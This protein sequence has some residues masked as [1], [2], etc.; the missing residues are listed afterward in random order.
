[1][2]KSKVDV[3]GLNLD[4]MLLLKLKS[5][6]SVVVVFGA[7]NPTILGSQIFSKIK[8]IL[9]EINIKQSL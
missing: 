5:L 3:A 7:V 8:I 9:V 1:M 2:I 4:A 6:D